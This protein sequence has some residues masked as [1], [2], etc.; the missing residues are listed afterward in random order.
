MM[1]RGM[2]KWQP[3]SAV[4]PSN[5]MI[6]DVLSK[7]NVVKMPILS[8]DQ[9]LTIQEKLFSS[10]QKKEIVTIWYF[11]AGRY[12]TIKGLV[13]QID[14]NT[15]KILLNDKKTLFFSQIIKIS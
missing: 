1:D 4:A 11:F 13:T 5:K 9:L 14:T 7:K 12:Y 3:F 6:N 10:F 15:H 8:E 2:I